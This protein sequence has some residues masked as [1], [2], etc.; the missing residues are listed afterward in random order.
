MN[1]CWESNVSAFIYALVL[2]N[3]IL[4]KLGLIAIYRT[5]MLFPSRK[6]IT[7]ILLKQTRSILQ[8]RSYVVLLLFSHSVVSDYLRPHGLQQDRL[9]V[10]H[11]LLEFAQ[12]HMLGHKTSLNKFMRTRITSSYCSNHMGMKLEINYRR[13]NGKN[14]N[15]WRLKI[16]FPKK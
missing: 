10:P 11:H 5:D 8:Y 13:K 15:T 16:M 7:H 6:N 3:D 9:P 1:L 12:V 2:L 4:D 14:T